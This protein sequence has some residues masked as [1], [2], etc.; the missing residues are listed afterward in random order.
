MAQKPIALPYSLRLCYSF[1]LQ[2]FSSYSVHKLTKSVKF[3][4]IQALIRNHTS[5]SDQDI[6]MVIAFQTMLLFNEVLWGRDRKIL[7]KLDSTHGAAQKLAL[8]VTWQQS[9]RLQQ[10]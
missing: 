8:K 2:N 6:G 7:V 10:K 5:I 4:M 9:T 3:N 1:Q